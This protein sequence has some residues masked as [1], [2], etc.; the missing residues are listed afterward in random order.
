MAVNL[1]TN[2]LPSE[3]LHLSPTVCHPV[4]AL[5]VCVIYDL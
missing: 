1:G 4:T 5:S 3:K 2:V